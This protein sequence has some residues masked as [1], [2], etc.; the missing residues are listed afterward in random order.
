MKILASSFVG[1]FAAAVFLNSFF[2]D[3]KM[4]SFDDDDDDDGDEGKLLSRKLSAKL[5]VLEETCTSKN[6]GCQVKM[7]SLVDSLPKSQPEM[8]DKTADVLVQTFSKY[9]KDFSEGKLNL[10]DL[11]KSE[12][13]SKLMKLAMMAKLPG[14]NAALKSGLDLIT[15]V[16]T[17]KVVRYLDELVFLRMSVLK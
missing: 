10:K 16:K 3:A 8:M 15:K 2:V 17:N 7:E 12:Y 13:A 5:D 14:G 11:L 1:F 9:F 6:E 4:P